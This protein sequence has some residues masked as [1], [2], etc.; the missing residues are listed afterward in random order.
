LAKLE[1]AAI[2]P[3]VVDGAPV[4]EVAACKPGYWNP[5][6]YIVYA[7]DVT[8]WLLVTVKEVAPPNAVIYPADVPFANVKID[9]TIA[10]VNVVPEP[11]I[12]LPD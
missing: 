2:V 8:V 11:V 3:P 7:C 1:P 12:V 10:A 4:G 9:P 5:G 6:K